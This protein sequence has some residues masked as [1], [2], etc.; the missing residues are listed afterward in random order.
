MLASTIDRLR[1]VGIP[2]AYMER[3]VKRTGRPISGGAALPYAALLRYTN[4][5]V[6]LWGTRAEP[7]YNRRWAQYGVNCVR[8]VQHL[9][10]ESRVFQILDIMEGYAQGGDSFAAGESTRLLWTT[11]DLVRDSILIATTAL[12][13]VDI[14]SA[15]HHAARAVE[16]HKAPGTVWSDDQDYV[17]ERAWQALEF[18]RLV[19]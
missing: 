19:G 5:E 18:L 4:L 6:A 9:V 15:A 7:R 13:R 16:Y 2:D 1:K 11:G 12:V 3:L 10:N 8:R 17:D 14:H